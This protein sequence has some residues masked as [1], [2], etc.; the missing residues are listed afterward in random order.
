MFEYY[1]IGEH[2]IDRYRERVDET[3]ENIKRRINR[4]LYFMKIRHIVNNGNTRHV[5]TI[6]SKEFIFVKKRGVWV[7]KTVIRR[8]RKVNNR[9]IQ[10]RKRVA[11]TA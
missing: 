9:A 8:N 1:I 6:G 10:H 11:A 2:V 7:L 3:V 5:F 4:D